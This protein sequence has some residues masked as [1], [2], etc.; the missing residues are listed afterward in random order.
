MIVLPVKLSVKLPV[1][2]SVTFNDEVPSGAL[3]FAGTPVRLDGDTV[4][5][6]KP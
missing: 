4:I 6:P 5:G 3:I 2:L 1:K